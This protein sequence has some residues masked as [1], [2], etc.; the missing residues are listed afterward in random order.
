MFDPMTLW[1]QS[2]LVWI[3]LFKQQQEL[4]FR[5][6]GSVAQSIPHEDSA[7]LAREAEALKDVLAPT[8]KPASE[9]RAPRAVAGKT[10][11]GGKAMVPA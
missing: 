4:Y 11:S 6:L 2:S 7:E 8:K 1:M 9:S 10:S 5:M 3:R